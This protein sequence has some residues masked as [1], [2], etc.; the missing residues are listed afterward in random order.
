VTAEGTFD[1]R[2]ADLRAEFD[3]AFAQP[4]D[5]AVAATVDLLALRVAGDR[6]ALR[7]ADL[8][9]L[10]AGTKVVPLASGRP[11]LVGVAGVRGALMP[12]YSLASLLGY[13]AR[14]DGLRWLAVCAGPDPTAL[15]FDELDGF[16]RVPQSSLYGFDRS[17]ASRPHL[18]E[19]ARI[20]AATFGV[21]DTRSILKVLAGRSGVK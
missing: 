6:Y 1:Q 20:E 5:R 12:V 17:D 2:A 16:R 14:S 10:L 21:V 15:A 7:M 8:G 19:V 11:E 13:G 3:D 18:S 4:I 9:G